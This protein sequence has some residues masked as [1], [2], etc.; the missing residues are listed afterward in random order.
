M[1]LEQLKKLVKEEYNAFVKEQ[2]NLDMDMPMAPMGANGGPDMSTGEDPEVTV[3]DNDIDLEGEN[4]EETLK[5][6][7]DM[8]KDFF[9]GDNKSKAPKADKGD[10]KPKAPKADKG[11][12]KPKAPK[13]DDKKD[14]K[15]DDKKDLNETILKRK[16]IVSKSNREMTILKERF[17]KLANII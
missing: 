13:D 6:I 15:D 5:A 10:D 17:K 16:N 2:D 4:P 1:K 12:D 14:D 3:S 9:E 7:F 11:D 8:L